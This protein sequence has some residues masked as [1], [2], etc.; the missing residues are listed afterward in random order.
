MH[1]LDNPAWTA[2][3]TR[4]AALARGR[5][6]AL[7]YDRDY[8]V[9]ATALDHGAESLAALG[10]LIGET[11]PAI[12]LEREALPPVPGTVVEKWREGVQMVA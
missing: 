3:R 11:G 12:V 1:P 10:A 4:Q 5:G 9:F 2:L 7:R 8:A 6:Q